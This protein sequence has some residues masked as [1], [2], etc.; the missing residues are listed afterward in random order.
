MWICWVSFQLSL[1]AISEPPGSCNSSTGSV[2]TGLTPVRDGP[3]PRIIT[4]FGAFPVMMKPP[5]ETFSPAC[6]FRREEKFRSWGG[7]GAAVGKVLWSGFAGEVLHPTQLWHLRPSDRKAD[8]RR[9][10][11]IAQ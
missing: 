5:I 2:R 10:E 3:M 7:H 9:P 6:T 8:L 11:S 4:F 1:L